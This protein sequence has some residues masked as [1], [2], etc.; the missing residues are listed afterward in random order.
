MLPQFV[1]VWG[2]VA[3][4]KA[5]GTLVRALTVKLGFNKPDWYRYWRWLDSLLH[6]NFGFS[7]QQNQTVAALLVTA[8]PKTLLLLGRQRTA[9]PVPAHRCWPTSCRPSSIRG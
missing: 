8:L 5:R 7:Y 6:G 3:H 2:A 9:D 1:R 4:E